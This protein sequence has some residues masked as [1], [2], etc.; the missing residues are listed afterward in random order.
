ML[1]LSAVCLFVL[2]TAGPHVNAQATDA[3][4]FFQQ[5]PTRSLF[6]RTPPPVQVAPPRVTRPVRRPR[7]DEREY[8]APRRRNP[9]TPAIAAVPPE[10][11]VVPVTTF[12]H[13]VGDSLSE[14]LAQGLKESLAQK[15]DIGVIRNTRSSSGLVRDDYHDWPKVLRDLLGGSEKID[16]LVMMI[17]SNDRQSLR[18]EAGVHEFR[19]DAWQNI[20][21]KRI[22]DITAIAREK[23]VP[24][25]WVGM[26]VMQSQRLSADLL[27]LNGLFKERAARNGAGYVD[28]WEGFVNDQGQYASSGPDVN[29]EIVKLRTVDGIHFTKAGSRKLG[30]FVSRETEQQLTGRN[31][32][33]EIAALP[34]DL[35][36]QIRRDSPGLAPQNLQSAL[37]LPA[38]LPERP[39]IR[40]RPLQGPVAALTAAPLTSGAQLLTSRLVIPSTEMTILIEQVMAYGRVPIA[41]TGRADDFRWPPDAAD[42]ARVQ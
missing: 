39:V 19:S 17:G 28:T 6:S 8:T 10:T 3:L 9:A 20:Y 15:P 41:K 27:Y 29:G 1:K 34:A 14:L 12:I 13:V 42:Q 38:E 26:P 22:D 32:G 37:T 7:D 25:V 2:A 21:N 33:T 4:R 30:F 31:R 36:E 18:D 23:R 5:N 35:S 16:L 24:I 11:A 40:E